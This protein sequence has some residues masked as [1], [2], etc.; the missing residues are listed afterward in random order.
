MLSRYYYVEGLT[1]LIG[2]QGKYLINYLGQVKDN[3]GN[4]VPINTDPEGFKTVN[5]LSWD[6]YK[7]Y[8]IV[9][10]MV[11]Q[12]KY[13]RIPSELYKNIIGFV[14]DGDHNNLQAKNIGY[15]F[16]NGKLEV[17]NFLGYYYIPGYSG[18]AINQDGVL[19]NC[20]NGNERKWYITKP[21]KKKN[22]KG[23]YF[24]TRG[25]SLGNTL[26][27][28]ARHRALC[29]VFKEYPNDVDKLVVNH[30]N[31]VPGSDG[32]DNLEWTTRG[33]NNLHAYEN[34]LKNQHRRTL[35]RDVRTGVV[36]EYFSV[37][38]T[39]RQLGHSSDATVSFRLLHTPFSKVHSDGLQFKFKDDQRDWVIPV[40]VESVI[41]DAQTKVA[42]TSKNCLT[43][44]EQTHETIRDA[45]LFTGVNDATIQYYLTNDK[46][47][48]IR[49][50]QFKKAD[51]GR[52]F[53][54]FTDYEFDATL[55][56]KNIPL[57][58]RNLLTGEIKDFDSRR[59]AEEFFH[60]FSIHSVKL[61]K[62]VLLPNGWQIKSEDKEWEEIEDLEKTLYLQNKEVMAKNVL[63]GQIILA[64]SCRHMGSVL[65]KC[66]KQIKEAALTRGIRV[67]AG[68]RFRLGISNED[69][70]H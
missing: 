23:G 64:D 53:T 7:D 8:R 57:N 45:G 4:D 41:K 39:A 50:Y 10:L 35:V 61:G 16:K 29:L 30:I 25:Y 36:T 40:D 28:I 55:E 42:V 21:D 59:S 43:G 9:D 37:A 31:G 58:A 56:S 14:I 26:T 60:P 49:G 38:E 46:R 69:W 70:P 67:Y 22:I 48:P 24:M 27:A 51:D 66:G 12:Y 6:G 11:L 63:T 19:I 20:F 44:V 33:L 34:N 2:S 17:P 3:L 13:I 5:V 62:S 32:L 68:H 54:N 52:E 18:V 65:N 1:G 15:R 47:N